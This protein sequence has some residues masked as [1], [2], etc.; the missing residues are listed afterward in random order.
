MSRHVKLPPI[1]ENS[2]K[3]IS[4]K[5]KSSSRF[6]VRISCQGSITSIFPNGDTKQYKQ[7]PLL[8]HRKTSPLHPKRTL[9]LQEQAAIIIQSIFRG[10]IIT[11]TLKRR[12]L[13]RVAKASGVWLACEGTVQGESGWY[14]QSEDSTPLLYDVDYLGQWKLVI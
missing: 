11:K 1:K 13:F 10:R 3:R 5:H 4:I 8:S 12:E 6:S 2:N 14:Q 7:K 9:E